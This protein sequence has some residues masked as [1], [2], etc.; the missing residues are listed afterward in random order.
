MQ[1]RKNVEEDPICLPENICDFH[2]NLIGRGKELICFSVC[3][4]QKVYFENDWRL[5]LHCPS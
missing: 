5:Y 2:S 4:S 1:R 3:R